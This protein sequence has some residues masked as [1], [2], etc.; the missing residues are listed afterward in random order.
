[1]TND[2][3]VPYEGAGDF[4]LYQSEDGSARVQ[5]R[6][7]EDTVWLTQRQMSELFQRG[8]PTINEHISNV[9]DEGELEPDSTIRK[10][11]IVQLEG[12]RQVERLV[13]HYNLEVI[14]AIGYRVRSH[15]G[16]QFRQWATA[17]LREYM[18]KGFVLDDQ[19]LKD[20]RNLEHDYFDE[21]LER[22]RDI[23]A[24][25]RRFYQKI[26]D[27]YATSVDYDAR[28]PL[29]QEFFATVQNKLHWA[30]HGH[31][32]AEIIADRADSGQPNMGLTT[33]RNAPAGRIRKAD[34]SVAKNYLTEDE[35]RGLNRIV[36]QYLDYA[37]D[38]AERRRAMTMEDWKSR[39]DA[40]LEFNE[41]EVLTD[42]GR[43]SHEVAKGLADAE[44][45][46]YDT[47]RRELEAAEPSS[48]FDH[49]VEETK[50]LAGGEKGGDA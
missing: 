38:Q 47:R 29:S 34:V 43:V 11:R 15:R 18:V 14:I 20:G 13:D 48:D 1:M 9:Y 42:A 12:Q 23:R 33:W 8:V 40:F 27:I 39:L 35:L 21:L 25:E 46:K 19:R 10:Y 49:F 30:I 16:T 28:H 7:A 17:L 26:T 2:G 6:L 41:R 22:I 3:I 5:V 45:E 4:Q 24:S 31:T 44:F 37:E 36:T 50:R 32:A